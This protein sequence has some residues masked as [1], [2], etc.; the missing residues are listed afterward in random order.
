MRHE[1]AGRT[2]RNNLPE[3]STE[4]LTG[5]LPGCNLAPMHSRDSAEAI[6]GPHLP[7]LATLFPEAWDRWVQ[8][9][10]DYPEYRIQFCKRTRA[11]MLHDSA[12]AAARREFDGKGP[13]VTLHEAFGFLLI[14]FDSQLYVRLKKFRDTT[15]LQTSGIPTGQQQA[16]AAQEPLT[17]MP[18]CTNLVLGYA[19]NSLGTELAQMAIT[20]STKGRL[21]WVLDVPI[22]ESGGGAVV[23]TPAPDR[24]PQGPSLTS[25]IRKK[26]KEDEGNGH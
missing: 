25:T 26:E 20:C 5:W 1:R 6:L 24:G 21:N 19:P 2:G 23:V 12:A 7:R 10:I 3:Y 11:T 15:R 8:F 18:E 4:Y 14:G 17:G 22:P 9:G 13:D 16:F